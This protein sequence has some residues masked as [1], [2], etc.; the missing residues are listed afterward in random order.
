MTDKQ[1]KVST[2]RLDKDAEQ[3]GCFINSME[4][5]LD[6][7]SESVGSFNG[8]WEGVSKDTFVKEFTKDETEAR[9]LLKRLK[10]LYQQ[11]LLAKGSYDECENQ[12]AGLVASMRI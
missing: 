7:M 6:N 1:F 9:N 2:N 10:A 5:A 12:V 4:K 11:E 8:E 3:V